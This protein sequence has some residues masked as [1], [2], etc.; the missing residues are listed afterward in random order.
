MYQTKD[1]LLKNIPVALIEPSISAEHVDT[2]GLIICGINPL[3]KKTEVYIYSAQKN[4]WSLTSQ[5]DLN[6]DSAYGYVGLKT[7]SFNNKDVYLTLMGGR[8]A[9]KMNNTINLYKFD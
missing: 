9:T 7:F 8:N 4:R 2:V 6:L 1:H 3:N 5:E